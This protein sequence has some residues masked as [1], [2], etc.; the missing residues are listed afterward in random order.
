MLS[1]S[2]GHLADLPNDL[3]KVDV[4]LPHGRVPIGLTV[5]EIGDVGAILS[6]FEQILRSLLKDDGYVNL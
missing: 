6:R 2:N 3:K 5:R 1:Y 4:D